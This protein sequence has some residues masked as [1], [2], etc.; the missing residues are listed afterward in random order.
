MGPTGERLGVVFVHGFRSSADMWSHFGRLMRDDSE[1]DFVTPLF[2]SYATSLLQWHP[3]RRIPTFETVADSLKEF[4]ST[5]AEELDKLVLVSHSQG[6]LI[7]QRYLARTLAEGRG[8]DLARIRRI[9]MFACPNAGSALGLPLRRRWLDGH[10]QERQLRPLDEQVAD[11]QRIVVN[12][13]VHATQITAS[14]CPI[15][16]TAYVA[17]S[18]GVV[19]RASAQSVFP[20][21]AALPGDH[22][23]IARPDA[24]THRSYR[25]L[26]R[27]LQE[28]HGTGPPRDTV[29][30]VG[31]QLLEVHPAGL[32][33][34]DATA[35]SF[36]TPYLSRVHDSELHEVLRPALDGGSSVLVMLTGDSS[37][38][39][40][41]ALY[42]ALHALA[43]GRPLVRPSAAEDL[44]ALLEEHRIE[45][46]TVLWLNE[47][48]RFLYGTVG[49]RAAARLRELLDR[50][51]GIVAVGTLWTDPY[52]R[53]LTAPGLPGGV[54][55]QARALL[56]GPCTR[57]IRVRNSLGE[58]EL[59]G[60]TALAREAGAQGDHRL[61]H[62]LAAGSRDGRVVQH[63]SGGPE[64]LDAYLQGPGECFTHLEHALIT[65][66]LDARR[67]GHQ[68]PLPAALLA[69]AA[70]GAVVPWVRGSAPDSVHVTLTALATGPHSTTDG[71]RTAVRGSLTPLTA[72]RPSSGAAAVYEPADYLDQHTRRHRGAELGS[73]AL[74]QALIE[75]TTDPYDLDRLA[76]AARLRGLY[77]A[78]VRLWRCAVLA[79]HSMSPVNLVNHVQASPETDP[80]HHVALWTATHADITDP[81][82][83]AALL[84]ALNRAG[85]RQAAEA[86]ASRAA[87]GTALGRPRVAAEL[88]KALGRA[89]NRQALT[90]FADRI[91]TDAPLDPAGHAGF[92]LTLL[93]AMREADVQQSAVLTLAGRVAADIPLTQIEP[94]VGLM[95]TLR[96]AGAQQATATL[97][98]RIAERADPAQHSAADLL[99]TLSKSACSRA[100]DTFAGRVAAHADVANPWSVV[101]LLE[102]LTAVGAEQAT[103]AL[104]DRA[105]TR[106]NLA[107]SEGVGHLLNALR[108]AGLSQAVT[109]LAERAISHEDPTEPWAVAHWLEMLT[110][111]GARQTIAALADRA[112]TRTPLTGSEGVDHLLNA[113]RSAGLSKA[114]DA[115][116]R[117]AEN[118]GVLKGQWRPYGR[119]TDGTPAQRWTCDSMGFTD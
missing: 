115:L 58:E 94:L 10:A 48:Q 21:T 74:W 83:V 7:V 23:T 97:A 11:T 54:R 87:T 69:D 75:H 64:L 82:A 29:E 100:T 101:P 96:E 2:F 60:W 98:E 81:E 36:L 117:R 93:Q 78:A 30:A 107:D 25:S 76:D 16:I 26:R 51:D 35:Y 27:Q 24:R 91:A 31:A 63:L 14:T 49:E 95:D 111:A 22:F 84:H 73:P 110:E 99:R 80:D 71:P 65:A 6:G 9:V 46:G 33:V 43:P 44:L 86:L 12:Q 17:E 61:A 113:L 56:T 28:A 45:A 38:G 109:A 57:H 3:F 15:P 50:H 5:E 112:V 108:S 4:L 105:V 119:E 89:G 116:T 42:E 52:W 34:S 77:K 37:T 62:A 47:S 103:T 59:H 19:G 88:L 18:D 104:V 92:V 114:A 8:P 41:R 55:A 53:E 67:L 32:P 79:G 66:A 1:L 72:L 40:T 102:A 90:T 13:I 106:T 70:D 39:K 118:A 20:Q 85:A 68:R